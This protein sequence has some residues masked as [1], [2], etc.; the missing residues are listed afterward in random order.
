MQSIQTDRKA[1]P[2][3]LLK[4][5]IYSM[6]R[7]WSLVLLLVAGKVSGHPLCFI[8]D[9]P[10]DVDHQL[11]FCPAAQDG[12]CCTDEEEAGVQERLENLNLGGHC[13]E[14]Y[15]QVRQLSISH[16]SGNIVWDACQMQ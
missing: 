1:G 3:I 5:H 13:K 4:Y 15:K 6:M 14:M 10:T 11:K 16:R 7:S 9:K 2:I 12:A 8:N